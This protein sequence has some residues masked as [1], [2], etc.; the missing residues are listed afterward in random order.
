MSASESD[1]L[2]TWKALVEAGEECQRILR[3]HVELT[4][5][6]ALADS[7]DEVRRLTLLRY[8]VWARY[9][10]ASER[11]ERLRDKAYAG[12]GIGTDEPPDE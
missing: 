9:E 4:A 11:A 6:I 12:L 5:R 7:S 1:L 3:E 10:A 2:E 8:E